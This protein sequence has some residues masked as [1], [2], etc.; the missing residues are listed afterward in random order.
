MDA[1]HFWRAG[2]SLASLAALAP[3]QLNYMQLCDAPALIPTDTQELIYQA[4]CARQV[5]GEGGLDL[6]SL[7]AALPA[8]LP[9]SVEV[10]LAGAQGALPAQQRAQLLFNAAQSFL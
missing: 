4:R 7:M 1:I 6:R 9:V 5:P 2:E 8:T 3:Q 10:P